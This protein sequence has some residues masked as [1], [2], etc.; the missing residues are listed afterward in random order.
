MRAMTQ[1]GRFERRVSLLAWVLVAAAGAQAAIWMAVNW[2]RIL[3]GLP[4]T[5]QS[6]GMV[7]LIAGLAAARR[8][9]RASAGQSGDG[10][11]ASMETVPG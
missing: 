7:V 4:W 2:Y 9:R 6:I 11:R 5:V 10:R 3:G 1:D 8:R